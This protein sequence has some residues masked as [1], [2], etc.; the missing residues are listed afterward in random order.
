MQMSQTIATIVDSNTG[1]DV[2]VIEEDDGSVT[3][4]AGATLDGDGANGQSG[5]PPCY[6][7]A[8]YAGSTL[9]VIGNAGHPGEWWGVVTDTGKPDGTPLVQGDDDPKPGAYISVTALNLRGDNG[10]ALPDRSPFKYVDSTGVPYISLPKLVIQR[11]S[12]V[13]LGCRCVVTNSKNDAAV[14]GVVA[15]SGNNDHIGEISLACAKAIGLPIGKPPHQA[16]RG[17]TDKAVIHYQ[18]FPGTAATVDG[19]TYPLQHS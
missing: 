13:V 6:A 16:N 3:F 15:D 11:A 7:P 4:I 14:E 9:D 17:G 2:D 1:T 19:V 10:Q 8:S 12:G 5:E 18:F